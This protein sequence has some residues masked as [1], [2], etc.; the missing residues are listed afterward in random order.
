MA[1]HFLNSKIINK[2]HKD[3][4]HMALNRKGQLFSAWELKQG[5]GVLPRSISTRNGWAQIFGT[6][7]MSPNGHK[8]ILMNT[9]LGGYNKMS[10]SGQIMKMDCIFHISLQSPLS[11]LLGLFSL[12]LC[13]G[14]WCPRTAGL[15][16]G[17]PVLWLLAGSAN[18]RP[19]GTL[20][21]R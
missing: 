20:G 14:G 21:I 4:K 16:S 8:S 5:G 3:V 17:L 15:H 7:C 10:A 1:L 18:G 11:A 9:D 6:L 12:A 2:R 13:S 19:S